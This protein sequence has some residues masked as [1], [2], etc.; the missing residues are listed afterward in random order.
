MEDAVRCRG[1]PLR[2]CIGAELS[3]E[4]VPEL[5]LEAASLEKRRTSELVDE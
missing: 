4:T 2:L 3:P 5:G 1:V